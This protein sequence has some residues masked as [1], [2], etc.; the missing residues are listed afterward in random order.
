[1]NMSFFFLNPAIFEGIE[2]FCPLLSG[3][4]LNEAANVP[5]TLSLP[6]EIAWPNLNPVP[7]VLNFPPLRTDTENVGCLPNNFPVLILPK[8]LGGFV[9]ENTPEPPV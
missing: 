7:I 8:P 2:M 5:P 3:V 1:M 4:T 6:V 9:W